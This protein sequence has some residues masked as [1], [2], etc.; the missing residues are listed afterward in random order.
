VS[1]NRMPH[2]RH[3]PGICIYVLPLSA[4]LMP[5]SSLTSPSTS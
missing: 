4:F 1:E 5:H 3:A 2:G